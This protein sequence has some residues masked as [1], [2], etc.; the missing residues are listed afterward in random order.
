MRLVLALT[1]LVLLGCNKSSRAE[2]RFY[3]SNNIPSHSD[4]TIE[5]QLAA[6]ELA[7]PLEDAVRAY[8]RGDYHLVGFLGVGLVIPGVNFDFSARLPGPQNYIPTKIISGT[9]EI[10]TSERHALLNKRALE[11]G[12]AYNSKMIILLTTKGQAPKL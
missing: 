8:R 6:I 1:T 10:I 5:S 7:D 3:P 2:I 9:G 12:T 11:Y 4:T